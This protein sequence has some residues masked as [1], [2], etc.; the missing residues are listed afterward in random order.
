MAFV[1]GI[2]V[3]RSRVEG[4]GRRLVLGQVERSS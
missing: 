4:G 3:E 2:L 1:L